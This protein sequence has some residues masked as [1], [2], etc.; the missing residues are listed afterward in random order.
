MATLA[1]GDRA[2][3]FSLLDQQGRHVNLA[4]FR[5]RTLLVY[6]YPKAD[7]PGCTRQACAVRDHR[8]DLTGL[9]IA[10]VGISPDRP[11]AQRKFDEKYG[12]GFPLLS[13]ADHRVAEAYGVWQ[14]KKLYGRES[15]GIV[16]SSF[17]VDGEGRITH[18][19]YKVKPEETV[20]VAEEAL[21][22]RAGTA[23]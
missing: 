4:D 20:V 11:E 7:T 9:G 12:L 10:V 14:T 23:P 13:D 18:T 8:A 16:R 17:L 1:P 15:K 6:F 21:R 5:G 19:W 2:P 3:E 22:G